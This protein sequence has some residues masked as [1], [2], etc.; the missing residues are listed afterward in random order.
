MPM[1]N[2]PN[3][4]RAAAKWARRAGSAGQEYSEGVGSTQAD[5]AAI[6]SA[7][8]GAW[9]A[10]VTAA[11][12]GDMF[13]KGVQRAGTAKWRKR[14]VELGPARYAQGVAVAE[15]DYSTGA[16]PYLE[17]IGRVDLPAR[18]VTGSAGNYARVQRIGDALHA[19][20]MRR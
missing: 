10:G 5:W 14:A 19:L 7:Q 3:I 11:A 8:K 12:A 15:P 13:S 1:P 4:A 20:R 16:G 2:G 6:T 18:G 17:A 9:Q